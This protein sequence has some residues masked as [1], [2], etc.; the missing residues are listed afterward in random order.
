MTDH[1]PSEGLQEWESKLIDKASSKLG[2]LSAPFIIVFYLFTVRGVMALIA[3]TALFGPA[4]YSQSE[5]TGE[6]VELQKEQ[7]ATFDDLRGEIEQLALQIRVN[8]ES[9]DRRISVIES[10]VAKIKSGQ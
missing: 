2:A 8:N 5:N 9:I 3:L 1:R 7:S 4:L 6:L 10:D